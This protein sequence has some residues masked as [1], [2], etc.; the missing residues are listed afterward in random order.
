MLCER[1]RKPARRMAFAMM[2]PNLTR[3]GDRVFR[4]GLIFGH[5][6]EQIRLNKILDCS[7]GF[8]AGCEAG[9]RPAVDSESSD[10]LCP[11]FGLCP[12]V[13]WA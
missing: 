10:G 2:F 4:S 9:L 5:V 8:A 1:E 7:C 11:R 3:P 13:K 12:T 6:V